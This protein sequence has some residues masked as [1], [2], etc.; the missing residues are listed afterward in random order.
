MLELLYC[1]VFPPNAA[2]GAGSVAFASYSLG[3][4][5]LLTA[6][7]SVI[8]PEILY[9]ALELRISL[10]KAK[11]V[12]LCRLCVSCSAIAVIVSKKHFC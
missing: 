5:S 10:E 8:T 9:K 1:S 12:S 4:I 3:K 6:Y 11:H 2:I 7:A